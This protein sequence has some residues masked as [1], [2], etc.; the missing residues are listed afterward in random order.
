MNAEAKLRRLQAAIE[1]GVEPAALV[2][3]I[4][5]A[6]AHRSASRAELGNVPAT[7]VLGDAKVDAL[8]ELGTG[9]S[10]ANTDWL[11]T[12]YTAVDLR[13]CY[14][15]DSRTADVSIEPLMRVNSECVRGGIRTHKPGTSTRIGEIT[16]ETLADSWL[17][18]ALSGLLL[19]CP[20]ST[21]RSPLNTWFGDISPS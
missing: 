18:D 20:N 8:V 16:P 1:A 15:H 14:D 11:T 4:N 3:S 5:E 13:V 6:Q 17:H 2:E 12:F 7:G 10:G 19:A 9:L 21:I